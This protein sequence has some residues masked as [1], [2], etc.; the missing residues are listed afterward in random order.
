MKPHT[1]LLCVA[2]ALVANGAFSDQASRK[3]PEN[4]LHAQP[5]VR[6]TVGLRDADIIGSDHRALQA[7][8]DYVGNLGGGVVEIGPGEFLM[9]DSLH[10]RSHVT[11]RGA[12]P[13]TV[14]KK[15]REYRSL[16]AADGDFGEAAITLQNP[17]GF[18]VGRGVYVASKTERTFLREPVRRF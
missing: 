8:V 1:I 15:D 6:I 14:L 11:V 4:E 7:A 16:L 17:E 10:L 5:A 3:S 12:G 2:V 13:Q 18:A 9:R